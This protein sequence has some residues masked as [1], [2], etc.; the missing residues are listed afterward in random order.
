MKTGRT[1]VELATELERQQNA[2]ADFMATTSALTF[3]S[4][5]ESHLNIGDGNYLVTDI[6]HQQIADRLQ[7]PK[8]Y[9]D[10]LRESQPG[11]LD[12]NV[13]TLFRSEPERRLVRTIDDRAR[14]FLSDKY[15]PLDHYDLANAV[16]PKLQECA[17]Q[18]ESCEITERRMYIKA[19]V[20]GRKTEIMPAGAEWGKGHQRVDVVQPGIVISNSEVGQG[21]VAIQPAIHTVHCT[22]LAVFQKDAMRKTHLGRANGNGGGEDQEFWEV[23]SDETKALDDQALWAKVKD[24]VAAAL[25][26]ALFD[27]IVKR[28]QAARGLHIEGDI[29]ATVERVGKVYSLTDSESSG[30]LKHLIEGGDLS[31]YGVSN[32]VTV[33]A[34]GLDDYD[35]AT[36]LEMYGARVID[37]TKDQ[38]RE[39][40][41]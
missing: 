26:G 37:L 20:P 1:L 21:A 13:N 36:E 35:R 28:L 6:C 30:V 10:R 2:K 40:A 3:K 24:I 22:N 7:I 19:I 8:K 41:A 9:Y 16:L 32:A 11:L 15:R 14:A 38:W 31:A 29:E 25:A 18:V 5:G 12:Y 33:T 27:K 39:I 34:Q 23:L 17:A 4:N